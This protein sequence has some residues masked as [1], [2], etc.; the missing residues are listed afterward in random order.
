MRGDRIQLGWRLLV[1]GLLVVLIALHG[2]D[3][4][5]DLD[6]YSMGLI[7]L[8]FV[9]ALAADLESARVGAVDV[10]FRKDQLAKLE[11]DVQELPK[12]SVTA[13]QGPQ[14]EPVTREEMTSEREAI[15]KVRQELQEI[16]IDSPAA[17][18]TALF[19]DIERG[20]G[21]LLD[22]PPFRGQGLTCRGG[23]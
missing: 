7:G 20:V 16:A 21:R 19:L 6:G 5:F 12:E 8:L 15:A 3:Q 1:S 10:K 2:F 4:A 9:L 23:L 14:H 18:V 17:A 22:R 13:G 11:K